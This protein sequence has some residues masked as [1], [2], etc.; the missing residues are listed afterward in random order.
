MPYDNIISRGDVAATIPETVSNELLETLTAESAAISL[1]R[2]VR[3][4]S[5]QTRMPVL[6]A[7]PQA[8]WVTG[9]TG[10]KQT[11]EVAWSNKYLNVEEL[12]AIV[13]IPEAVADDMQFNIWDNVRPLL[14]DAIVRAL[15]S[16]VFLGINKPASWPGAIVVDAIAAGNSVARTATATELPALLSDLYTKVELDGFPV[17][18]NIA[19]PVMRGTLRRSA[20]AQPENALGLGVGPNDIFGVTPGYPMAGLWLSG[21]GAADM[22]VGSRREGII[23]IRQDMQWRILDQAAIFDNNG[24]LIFNF[25]QQDMVGLRVTF[26]AAYQV[27]NTIRYENLNNATRYPFAVLT[28]P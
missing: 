24:D 7:L 19:N 4:S 12:A 3:M 23:G 17:D 26:R 25:A 28:A 10:L 21:T 2:T 1:F 18:F 20:L 14:S 16:A 22:I 9:D 15:D 5:N 6:A 13:P 8:Y 11:T 27:A